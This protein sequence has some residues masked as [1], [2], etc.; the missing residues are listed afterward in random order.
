MQVRIIDNKKNDT[1]TVRAVEYDRIIN[2]PVHIRRRYNTGIILRRALLCVSDSELSLVVIDTTSVNLVDKK[3]R[4]YDVWWEKKTDFWWSSR[5]QWSGPIQKYEWKRSLLDTN[6][7]L[8]SSGSKIT[9]GDG[10]G[11]F[12]GTKTGSN[13]SGS[14]SQ[15]WFRIKSGVFWRIRLIYTRTDGIVWSNRCFGGIFSLKNW[16][17]ARNPK[18][19]EYELNWLTS[20]K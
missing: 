8:I 11:L 6:E 13:I 16:K 20:N 10:V 19:L 1:T 4:K 3:I 12:S 14:K 18:K 7:P 9:Y 17:K 15:V 5:K 2:L